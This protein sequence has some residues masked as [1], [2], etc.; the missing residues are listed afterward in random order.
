[1]STP[2]GNQPLPTNVAEKLRQLL[3]ELEEREAP[4]R[5]VID[6]SL[7]PGEEAMWKVSYDTSKTVVE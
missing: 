6:L 7:Q 1:M 5:G 4:I 3:R 2:R